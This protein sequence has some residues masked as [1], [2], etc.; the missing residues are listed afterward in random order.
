MD[1]II[2]QSEDPTAVKLAQVVKGIVGN[3]TI[4]QT[5]SDRLVGDRVH[6]E[7][8]QAKPAAGCRSST[9]ASPCS[10]S[11][12]GRSQSARSCCPTK[13]TS[14]IAADLNQIDARAIAV[15]AQDEAYLQL[16]T[17]ERDSHAEI[18]EMVWGDRSRREDAKAIRHGW[19]YGMGLK[20][21]A[22]QAKVDE[23]V[24]V[25]FDQAMRSKFPRLVQ[26]RDEVR[27]QARAGDS[28][29]NGFRA[30]AAS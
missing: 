8:F 4:Y 7:V 6:P 11:A 23:S 13:A 3:R 26:W 15:H 24:A 29:D 17:G 22:Y 28:L 9:L 25:E 27:E 16:F 5:V 2:E 30:Q 20:G 21:I 19:N 1:A 14:S 18:A 10:A 12:A